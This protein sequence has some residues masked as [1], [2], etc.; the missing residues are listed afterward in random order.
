MR[1]SFTVHRLTAWYKEGADVQKW[2]PVLSVY[3][4]HHRLEATST[5]LT[6]TPALLEEAGR[7]F[8]QYALKEVAHD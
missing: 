1:H 4:G 6:M 2:L 8:E 7:R 5:Y 3:L